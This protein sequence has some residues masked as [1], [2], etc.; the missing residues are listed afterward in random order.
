MNERKIRYRDELIANLIELDATYYP[1]DTDCFSTV[2]I[3]IIGDMQLSF[4]FNQGNHKLINIRLVYDASFLDSDT[5]IHI[6][7][8][9]LMMTD[10][11]IFV[12]KDSKDVAMIDICRGGF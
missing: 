5:G 4:I 10:T 2:T 12:M 1:W 8:D 3:Y 11:H 9:S 6:I 7:A